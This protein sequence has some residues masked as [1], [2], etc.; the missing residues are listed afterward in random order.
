VRARVSATW[1]ATKAARAARRT[2]RS[3]CAAG[4]TRRSSGGP[5]RGEVGDGEAGDDGVDDEPVEREA[6]LAV[7]EKGEHGHGG[8]A[9]E[10][11]GDVEVVAGAGLDDDHQLG[12]GAGLERDDGPREGGLA[13][14]AEEG[15]AGRLSAKAG[16][17]ASPGG[18][19]AMR[20][21]AQV[22]LV[23]GVVGAEEEA[24]AAAGTGTRGRW[25]RGSC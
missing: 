8:E 4:V 6:R 24:A 23:V 5:A 1:R 21:S 9:G 14:G 12:G 15:H 7:E 2:Q 20:G 3:R 18:R 22:E 11:E 10:G 17:G 16:P 25:R 13:V 19:G